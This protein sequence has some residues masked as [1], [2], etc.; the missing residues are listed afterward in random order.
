[1]TDKQNKILLTVGS[2]VNAMGF[3]GTPFD[4]VPKKSEAAKVL[5]DAGDL[6]KSSL[7]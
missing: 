3:H 5:K 1:V 2:A 7:R 6:S 4:L